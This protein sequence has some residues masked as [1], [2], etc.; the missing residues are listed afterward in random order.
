MVLRPPN[1][2]P[3]MTMSLLVHLLLVS[4][5]AVDMGELMFVADVIA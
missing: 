4:A 3:E 5:V 2:L 1:F